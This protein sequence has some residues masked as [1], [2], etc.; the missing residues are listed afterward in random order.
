[1]INKRLLEQRNKMKK[2]KPPF[3]VR[4]SNFE[5]RIKVRWRYPQGRHSA[6]RQEH[7]GRPVM[8]TPGYGSPKVVYGLHPS[9]LQMVVVSNEKDLEKIDAAQQ[10]VIIAKTVGMRKRTAL[11]EA[12]Q[13]RKIKVLNCKDIVQELEAIRTKLKV[14]QEAKK[15]LEEQ[16]NK[17][18]T[19][20][21]K[22]AEEKKKK[23]GQEKENVAKEKEEESVEEKIKKEEEEKKELEKTIT[24]RQ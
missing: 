2:I 4:E 24:K 22:K 14:R 17:K 1:M 21:K 19:E 11:L 15:Q 18:E 10:G 20:K 12:V 23:E 9:G 6:I 3:V 8:P 16:K 5:A 13:R 7:K